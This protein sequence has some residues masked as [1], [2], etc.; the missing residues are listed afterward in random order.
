MKAKELF[1]GESFLLGLSFL[2]LY[3]GS[4]A[5]ILIKV[6]VSVNAIPIVVVMNLEKFM[7]EL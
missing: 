1:C 6:H 4:Q 5:S 3:K 2:I 7:A